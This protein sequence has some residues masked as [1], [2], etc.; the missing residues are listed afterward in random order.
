MWVSLAGPACVTHPSEASSRP[1]GQARCCPRPGESW[2][3]HPAPPRPTGSHP[4]PRWLL[5]AELLL[6]ASPGD[7][8]HRESG[9]PAGPGSCHGACPLLSR[10]PKSPSPKTGETPRWPPPGSSQPASWVHSQQVAAAPGS[11]HTA[12]EHSGTHPTPQCPF[13]GAGCH[14]ALLVAFLRWL[15]G[16]GHRVPDSVPGQE[17]GSGPQPC[18]GAGRPM[19]CPLP[20]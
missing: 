2:R 7:S 17:C 16:R 9:V 4:W 18:P 8:G 6:P 10:W 12:W 19:G 15:R 11:L 3:G 20:A 5:G 13:S 1:P 14:T